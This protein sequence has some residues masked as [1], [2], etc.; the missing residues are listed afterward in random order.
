M[1]TYIKITT[2]G[3]HVY[4]TS[5]ISTYNVFYLKKCAI[6]YLIRTGDYKLMAACREIVHARRD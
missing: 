2:K 1:D 6:V 4:I 5:L 3:I